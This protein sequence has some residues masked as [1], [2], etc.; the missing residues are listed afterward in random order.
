MSQENAFVYEKT[1]TAPVE[2]IYRAFT[3]STALREWLCDIATTNPEEGGWIY[4]VWNRGYFTSGYYTKLVPDKAVSF[5]WIGKGEP[6]WTNVD[7]TITPF[8]DEGRYKVKLRHSGIG[9]GDEW[10][11]AREEIS[12]GW[13]LGLKNLK[14]T[15][16]EGKDLRI[17]ERPLI[18]IY[19]DDLTNL[20]SA[21]FEELNV[22]VNKGVKVRELVPGYGADLA[23][24]Q[25]GDVITAVNGQA[26]DGV[27]TLL[28]LMSEFVAGDKIS[29]TAY[30]EN[31]KNTFTIDTKPQKVEA[32][33]GTPEELAKVLEDRISNALES[34]EGVLEN[35]T[36]AEASYSP[37]QDEW[38]AKETLVHLIHNEREMHTWIN[39][40]VA[41]QERFHD[42]WSGDQL[43][44]IRATLTTY[45]TVDDLMAELKRSLKE[46]VATVAFLD[47]S[48]T[49]IKPSYWRL[50]MELLN[51]HNHI[52]EHVQQIEDTIHEARSRMAEEG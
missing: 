1:I 16:E 36:D 17:V 26:V 35:V 33:P 25:Q 5:K 39:D 31:T 21:A 45:P 22:P 29:V 12:K 7:V 20:P 8:D 9:E 41:G 3:Y 52:R 11:K 10:A 51:S 15:L 6:A 49:R 13:A 34:L 50:G 23:G 19:P 38:S 43:F 27:R 2:L 24:I 30:R 32:L 47:Q 18:G 14:S 4:M 48:F 37:G 44:R 28:S 42:Q 40:V 46:T